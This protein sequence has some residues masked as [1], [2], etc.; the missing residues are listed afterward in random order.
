MGKRLP[1]TPRSRIKAALRQ[2]WMRSRERAS[3]LKR[4]GYCCEKCGAKQSRAKG[5]EVYLEV[6]HRDGIQWE[7]IMTY[8]Y[9]FLLPSPEKL[10]VLC[11]DCHKIET[12]EQRESRKQLSGHSI[13]HHDANL[14]T[15]K[16]KKAKLV[17]QT[18]KK[19]KK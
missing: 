17:K 8:I 2:L 5:K 14:P 3:A 10:E 18:N 15:T 13:S 7:E 11:L 4:E 19:P 12:D 9:K 6:H 1:N 16:V